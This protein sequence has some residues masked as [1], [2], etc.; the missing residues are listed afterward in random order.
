MDMFGD[1]SENPVYCRLSDCGYCCCYCYQPS[2]ALCCPQMPFLQSVAVFSPHLWCQPVHTL[3]QSRALLWNMVLN[4][5]KGEQCPRGQW[6][7]QHPRGQWGEQH[8][9]GQSGGQLPRGQWG[10]QFPRGQWRGNSAPGD[11]RGNSA[12]GDS[13]GNS[14]PG[15]S[16]GDNA[17]GDSEGGTAPQGMAGDVWRHSLCHHWVMATGTERSLNTLWYTGHVLP[18]EIARSDQPKR[19][20]YWGWETLRST[21]GVSSRCGHLRILIRAMDKGQN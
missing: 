8:S 11:S 18:I 4:S 6:G 10:G 2:S 1:E 21:W 12:P 14:T 19:P 17:P 15:D 16:E 3:P 13:E 20:S 9:R 7:E 5:V